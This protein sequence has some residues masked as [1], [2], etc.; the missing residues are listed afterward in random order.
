[1][2]I[3]NLRMSKYGTYGAKVDNGQSHL[4]LTSNRLEEKEMERV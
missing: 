3:H 2:F 1:M 4:L